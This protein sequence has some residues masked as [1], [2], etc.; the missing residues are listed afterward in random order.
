ME[1]Y[2]KTNYGALQ[3]PYLKNQYIYAV[4]LTFVSGKN[5]QLCKL[6]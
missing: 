5:I 3:M 1:E 2:L 6:R 4:Y